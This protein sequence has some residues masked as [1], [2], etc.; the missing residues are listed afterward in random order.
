MTA[1]KL[2]GDVDE[3]DRL[4]TALVLV[5]LHTESLPAALRA[6]RAAARRGGESVAMSAA[7]R[8]QF[9]RGLLALDKIIIAIGGS[10]G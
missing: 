1:A 7:A 10:R 2:A 6:V 4:A 8:V 9:E 3:I 5:K